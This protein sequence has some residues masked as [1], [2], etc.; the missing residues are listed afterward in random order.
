MTLSAGEAFSVNLKDD[1]T[2]LP[3]VLTEVARL[4][5][6]GE[7]SAEGLSFAF[8]ESVLFCRRG[9]DLTFAAIG[10]EGAGLIPMYSSELT[11]FRGEGACGWFTGTG[12]TLLPLVPLGY[13]V[14]LDFCNDSQVVLAALAIRRPDVSP[15]NVTE[16]IGVV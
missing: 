13:G 11:L 9:D 10:E 14:V 1:N 15:N 12:K 7:I 8:A 3:G 5:R 16:S 6:K 4:F 2:M